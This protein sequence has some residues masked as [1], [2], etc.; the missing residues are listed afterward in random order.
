[1]ALGLKNNQINIYI[2]TENVKIMQSRHLFVFDRDR[3]NI[4]DLFIIIVFMC[5]ILP[6][7]ILTW[8]ESD[9]ITNNTAL[10]MAGYLYG[11]N[12][13]LLTFRAFGSVLETCQGVG[14]IQ[15]ALTYIVRDGVV[16]V[17]HVLLITVAFASTITK[18]FVAEKSMVKQGSIGTQP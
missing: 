1:M 13:M 10:V 18:V 2:W 3:W 7:R 5:A 4:F 17:L 15:I 11:F 9:S 8:V 14:T 12:T 6:L 16:V